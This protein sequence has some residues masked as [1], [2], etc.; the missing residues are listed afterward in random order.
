MI[1]TVG[2][3]ERLLGGDSSRR[4][5]RVAPTTGSWLRQSPRAGD[6]RGAVSFRFVLAIILT[7][8]L[9]YVVGFQSAP[10]AT[11]SAGNLVTNTPITGDTVAPTPTEAPAPTVA[12][13]PAGPLTTFGEGEYRVGTQIKAGHVS[14]DGPDGRQLLLGA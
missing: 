9:G 5:R 1:H 4:E 13:K 6:E 14:D 12:P 11:K 8:V 2:A 7:F 10:T 3:A